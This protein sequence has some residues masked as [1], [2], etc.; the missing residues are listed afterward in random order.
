MRYELH[1]FREIGAEMLRAVARLHES[2][3]HVLLTDLGHPFVLKYYQLASRDPDVIGFYAL[4]ERGELEGF[5]VGSPHPG[6]INSALAKPVVWFLAQCLRLLV[7]RPG[8]LLQAMISTLSLSG[9]SDAT[10][11]AI[12][13][14]YVSVDPRARGHGLG[15]ALLQAF[16]AASRSSGYARV[17][18]SQELDNQASI[19]LFASLGYR[20][21]RKLREGHYH[22]QRVELI[23]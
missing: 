13:L 22:R 12:E 14:V 17:T 11:D 19:G 8:V 18:A 6:A 7:T 4:S 1:P 10:P 2:T 15:R 9:Q 21:V 5:V 16:H 23:L 3:M 20:V